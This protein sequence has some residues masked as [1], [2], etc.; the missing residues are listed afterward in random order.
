MLPHVPTTPSDDDVQMLCGIRNVT[1]HSLGVALLQI[2]RWELFDTQDLVVIRKAPAKPSRLGPRYDDLTTSCL[3]CDFGFG[4]DHNRP[5]LQGA[6]YKTVIY[7]LE[8]MVDLLER[9]CP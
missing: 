7:E 8:Q 3:W 4:A 2:W 6:I 9:N 1:L 5:Q